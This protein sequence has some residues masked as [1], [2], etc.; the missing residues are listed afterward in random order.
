MTILCSPLLTK[1]LPSSSLLR[2][3]SRKKTS[4]ERKESYITIFYIIDLYFG[5]ESN[6]EKMNDYR[7]SHLENFA[8]QYKYERIQ[9]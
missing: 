2:P 9:F 7:K 6:E 5:I 1:R 4:L 8:L 3:Q